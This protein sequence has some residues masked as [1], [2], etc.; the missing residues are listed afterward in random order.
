MLGK[1]LHRIKRQDL[2]LQQ[3][4][5][6][7]VLDLGRN[8]IDVCQAVEARTTFSTVV[9]CF[10]MSL[11]PCIP[12]SRFSRVDVEVAEA[13]L[14]EDV[15]GNRSERSIPGNWELRRYDSLAQVRLSSRTSA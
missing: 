3:C 13:I 2:G 10:P 9:S 5:E 1:W 12:T 11:A 14:A 7:L 15:I 4:V 6:I 8:G